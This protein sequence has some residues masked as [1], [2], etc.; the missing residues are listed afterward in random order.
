MNKKSLLLLLVFLS[1]VFWLLVNVSYAQYTEA[2]MRAVTVR[3][4]GEWSWDSTHDASY[5]IEPGKETSIRLCVFNGWTKEVAF[6]YWF[7]RSG[8][9]NGRYCD[10][11]IGTGNSFSM[12]IPWT[13][14]RTV[15][16]G[17]MTGLIVE[18]KI[19]IPP[20][21]SGLQLGCIGY[22]LWVPENKLVWGMFSLKIR[23]VGYI[24]IMVG[25]E[26]SVKSSIKVLDTVWGVFSTNKKVKAEVD[27]QN[28]LKLGFLI[29]NAGNISQNISITGTITNMLGFEKDF[30]ITTQ[31]IAPG[32]TSEL[33]ANVGILPIYKWLYNISFNIQ[34]TPQFIF[35]IAN[36]KLKQPWYMSDTASIFIFSR[37]RVVVLIIVL[38][39]LYKLFAPRRTRKAT[40]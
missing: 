11:D 10:G 33:K 2:D 30:S 39:L 38:L 23:K 27:G 18:E 29:E 21:M 35:P 36:E 17:P 19:V 20:G 7:S 32:S 1:G 26:S 22:N 9:W 3:F 28:R 13:K 6:D 31:Q 15:I 5:M 37:I 8:I 34:N 12:L 24:D 16:I 4:C 25:W 14:P 40:A